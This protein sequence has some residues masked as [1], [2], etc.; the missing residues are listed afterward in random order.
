[1]D[2]GGLRARA[3]A[4]LA[5]VLAITGATFAAVGGIAPPPAGAQMADHATALRGLMRFEVVDPA[6]K[7]V[8]V[9][10]YNTGKVAVLDFSGNL[11]HTI[12][13]EAGARGL[14][15]VGNRLYVAA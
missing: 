1:M 15:V 10:L 4:A 2:V 13:T 14:A 8:F 11:A 7:H 5:S 6:S 12:I 9:S 3:V